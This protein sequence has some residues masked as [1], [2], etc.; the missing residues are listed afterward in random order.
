MF[1]RTIKKQQ[2]MKYDIKKA[3]ALKQPM[4]GAYFPTW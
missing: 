4:N 1:A 3:R 2:L